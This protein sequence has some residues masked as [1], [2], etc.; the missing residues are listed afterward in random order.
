MPDLFG[1]DIAG[2]IATA[3]KGKLVPG[4]LTKRASGTRT[5]GQLTGGT[6]PDTTAHAF[7]GFI[8]DKT[9]VRRG[10]TLVARGGKFVTVLAASINPAAEPETG[11]AI[12]IEGVGY[13]IVEIA[14]RDPAGAVFE[15]RVE[16]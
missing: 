3:F 13:E 15:C 10:G 7:E 16:K 11:D 14:G 1:T 12:N 2:V 5:P 8:E 9:E 4:T 6:N